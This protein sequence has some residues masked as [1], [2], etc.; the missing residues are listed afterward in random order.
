MARWLAPIFLKKALRYPFRQRVVQHWAIATRVNA[1]PLF[2]A[3]SKPNLNGFR[4][5]EAPKG[6]FWA[7]P[8]GFACEG[9]NW[10][11]FEEYSYAEKRAWIA[12]AEISADGSLLP[13]VRCLDTPGRHYSYPYIFRDGTDIFMIPEAY[14]S[15]SVD[16]YRCERFPD[17]WVHV[18]NM[19]KGKFVDTSVWKDQGL[20]WM[21]TTSVDPNPRTPCLFLFYSESLTGSWRF[22][23]ANPISTD[24]RNN[25][26]AG[27]IFQAH[28]RWIR[29]SQ[30]CCPIYG[31]S[32]SLNEVAKLSPQEYSERT[33]LTVT[34]PDVNKDLCAVHTYNWVGNVELLDGARMLAARHVR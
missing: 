30:S 20:W 5:I 25:R 1:K 14:D 9:K 16:L 8:F 12:C 4:F 21:M 23:P 28:G 24:V 34:P 11:F 26:G 3:N 29:P 2:A 10:A 15:E 22:H 13:S 6:H 17:K 31:Y 19:L 18:E 33:L 27:R 32:F 7:D